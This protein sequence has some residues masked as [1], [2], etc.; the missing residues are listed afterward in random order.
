[1]C[2][3]TDGRTEG[4]TVPP[5]KTFVNLGIKR[6]LRNSGFLRNK[7]YNSKSTL[8]P[9]IQQQHFRGYV[10]LVCFNESAV[11]VSVRRHNV[12]ILHVHEKI[13]L[14]T[15]YFQRLYP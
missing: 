9:T 2:S 1:M 13:I 5:R 10:A 12:I 3:Q 15:C 11:K 7:Q 14:K 4:G 6:L 8:C